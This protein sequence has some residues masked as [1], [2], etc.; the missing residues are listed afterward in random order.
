MKGNMDKETEDSH[1]PCEDRA[2][3]KRS[4]FNGPR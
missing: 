2:P 1:P 4:A 3:I